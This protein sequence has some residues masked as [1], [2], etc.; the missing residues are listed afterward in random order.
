MVDLCRGYDVG[1]SLEQGHVQNHALCLGNKAL[2][3]VLAGL[4]IVLTATPGQQPLAADLGEGAL[5]YAP[6]D[7][8]TLAK[9]LRRWADDR[10]ML[11]RARAAAWRG[12][13][14]RWHW[15]HHDERGALL[16]AVSGIVR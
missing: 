16:A 6:G 10:A 8:A 5:V 15:E 13:R 4:A 7:V 14:E 9:G 1:L 11:A 12:A 2:T 3:Y